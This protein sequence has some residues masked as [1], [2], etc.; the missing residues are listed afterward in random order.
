MFGASS[1]L[2]NG[3]HFKVYFQGMPT[4][5]GQ[6]LRRHGDLFERTSKGYYRAHGR[7]DDT[8][9]LGG[10]KVG[11]IEIER[12]CNSVDDSVLETAAIG[13]PP[14]S[15]GPE[16]LVIAV[17]FKSPEFSNPDLNLLKKSFNSEIQK[18]LN[19]LFKVS[20]VV[21]LPSLPRTAT[22]KVMRRVLRQQLTQTGLNSKL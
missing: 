21:T 16:Q 17:V 18:K 10:I 1:T 7:A 11:S 19:P 2:L 8:M 14:P 6:I 15:G 4:F 5:Q 13:V 9:N 20:S 12:V 22:N 3:N